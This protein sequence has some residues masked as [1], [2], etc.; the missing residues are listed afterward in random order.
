MI[1]RDEY[2]ESVQIEYGEEIVDICTGPI[3]CIIPRLISVLCL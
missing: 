2:V 3:N 1:E